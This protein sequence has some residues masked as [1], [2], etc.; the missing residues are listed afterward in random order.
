MKDVFE[1]IMNDKESSDSFLI[2]QGFHAQFRNFEFCF[3][4]LIFDDIFNITDNLFQH[5]QKKS[6]DV[7]SCIAKIKGVTEKISLKRNEEKFVEFFEAASSE[8]AFPKQRGLNDDQMKQKYKLLFFEVID[9][10]INQFTTRFAD[11]E[12]LDF[13]KLADSKK[14]RRILRE[15]PHSRFWQFY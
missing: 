13:L 11:F 5:L 6:L 8:T 3:L 12:K 1:A 4:S 7:Q 15:I 14:N 10:I 9:I 2:A